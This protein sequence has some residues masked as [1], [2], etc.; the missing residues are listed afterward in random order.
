MKSP[1]TFYQNHLITQPSQ[2]IRLQ[3]FFC[4]TEKILFY[5]KTG[6]SSPNFLSYPDNLLYSP[7]MYQFGYLTIKQFAALSCFKHIRE[8]KCPFFSFII[9]TTRHKVKSNIQR[10]QIRIITIIDQHTAILALFYRQT[11]SNLFQTRHALG[12]LFRGNHHI[13]SHSQTMQ[14]ILNRSVIYKRNTKFIRHPQITV[15]NSG[16]MF[17]FLNRL[18]KQRMFIVLFRPSNL[19]RGKKRFCHTRT[20]QFVIAIINDD[21]TVFEQSKLLH[22]FI[23]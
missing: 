20:D 1:R 11:H 9:R 7:A 12:Y 6:S 17:S 19:T 18:N 15:F 13:Q 16:N 14:R 8:D 3:Q 5:L 10:S 21:V 23:L 22:T 4:S 2:Q